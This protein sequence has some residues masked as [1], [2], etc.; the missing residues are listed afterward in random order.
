MREPAPE[1]ILE[2]RASH[3]AR[4]LGWVAAGLLLTTLIMAMMAQIVVARV[5]QQ[6]A[7]IERVLQAHTGLTVKFESMRIGWGMRGVQAELRDV[8][9]SG[10]ASDR[11]RATAPQVRVSFNSW[12]LF[13]G[14]ELSLGR[15]TLISP[16]IDVDLAQFDLPP[17]KRAARE[18][19]RGADAARRSQLDFERAWIE[20]AVRALRVLPAGRIELEAATLRVRGV[21]ALANE[22]LN[23]TR[24]VLRREADAAT[25]YGTFLLPAALGKTAF[26]SVDARGLYSRAQVIDADARIIARSVQLNTLLPDRD[27]DGFATVDARMRVVRGVLTSG[28]WQANLRR[29]AAFDRLRDSAPLRFE[30]ADFTGDLERSPEQLRVRVDNLYVAPA[31]GSS[32]AAEFSI[33]AAPDGRAGMLASADVPLPVVQFLLALGSR[34]EQAIWPREL[35]T[36]SGA[37]RNVSLRWGNSAASGASTTIAALATDL[38]VTIPAAGLRIAGIRGDLSGSVEDWRFALAPEAT[39]AVSQL[40]QSGPTVTSARLAGAIRVVS[41]DDDAVIELDALRAEGAGV[42]VALAGKTARSIG[43]PVELVAT[44]TGW[45]A[46]AARA[47]AVRVAPDAPFT[48]ALSGVSGGRLEQAELQVSGAPDE[49]GIVPIKRANAT[50]SNLSW[51]LRDDW[52]NL[53]EARATVAYTPERT[54]V[55]VSEGKLDDVRIVSATADIARDGAAAV[56]ATALAP[57]DSAALRKALPRLASLNMR[58]DALLDLQAT[59]ASGATAPSRWRGAVRLS[60]GRLE[61]TPGIPAIA[62]LRGALNVVDGELRRSSLAGE[63]LGGTLQVS[64]PNRAERNRPP[65]IALRGVASG[66]ELAKSLGVAG[67]AALAGDVTWVGSLETSSA[68]EPVRLTLESSL[69]GLES[70]LPTPFA[71]RAARAV[72][73]VATLNLDAN[74]VRAFEVRSNRARIIQGTLRGRVADANFELAGFSGSLRADGLQRDPWQLS[75]ESLDVGQ[76]PQLLALAQAMR[77]ARDASLLLD[78]QQLR[79]GGRSYGAFAARVARRSDELRIDRIAAPALLRSGEVSAV[80]A[81]GCRLEWQLEAGPANRLGELLGFGAQ[82]A[83]ADL[84]IAGALTWPAQSGPSAQSL[85]GRFELDFSDGYVREVSVRRPAALADALVA[86]AAALLESAPFSP[87]ASVPPGVPAVANRFSLLAV[88]GAFGAGVIN[89]ESWRLATAQGDLAAHGSMDVGERT[90]DWTL[91]WRPAEAVPATVAELA[92]RPR[93]AAAWAA[94]KARVQGKRDSAPDKPAPVHLRGSWDA[95]I[96]AAAESP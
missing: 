40:G 22:S 68:G 3:W 8:R 24:A 14:G 78:A 51:S 86:P 74:G 65:T 44:I 34:G 94:F 79:A 45:D 43:A 81:D 28:N 47:Y 12:G 39:V 82:L 30:R 95:P 7:T 88:R 71:K 11:F 84:R 6:R 67:S 69:A 18:P 9:L 62:R 72:P 56:R 58:G 17:A 21:E 60:E 25:V 46:A 76:L 83:G 73:V 23:I 80:C 5:P 57:V 93:L 89:V 87:D 29:V 31:E 48:R 10:S 15:V 32:R 19:S 26:L 27:L 41:T 75:L 38:A 70:S 90:Y 20:R 63:W 96:L 64:I 4:R 52:Q 61:L 91:E 33:E 59:I 35:D 55:R 42:G 54:E 1:A 85:S 77:P 53:T 49:H 66:A 16:T 50:L 92:E 13:K 37:L 36:A 2:E